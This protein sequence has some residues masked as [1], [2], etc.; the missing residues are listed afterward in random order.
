[1]S[2]EEDAFMNYLRLKKVPG[3]GLGNGGPK[4]DSKSNIYKTTEYAKRLPDSLNQDEAP[5]KAKQ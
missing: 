5:K 4:V 2:P 1:M 3:K